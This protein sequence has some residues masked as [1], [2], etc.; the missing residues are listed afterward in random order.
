MRQ[1]QFSLAAEPTQQRCAGNGDKAFGRNRTN[2]GTIGSVTVAAPADYTKNIHIMKQ[3]QSIYMG[4]VG[5]AVK[6]A[7]TW[8][9]ITKTDLQATGCTGGS[10]VLHPSINAYP[11]AP[12]AT[13][14]EPVAA[15]L[16]ATENA[17]ELLR[18]TDQEVQRADNSRGVASR[19]C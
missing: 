3:E 12:L 13:T 9:K 14:S 6:H 2:S 10:S 4:K 11:S 16:G 18:R 5:E 15:S 8:V 19:P 7:A 17:G 1:T